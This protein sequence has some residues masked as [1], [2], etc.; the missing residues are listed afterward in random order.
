ML[1]ALQGIA[2]RTQCLLKLQ[3]HTDPAA[4]ESNFRILSYAGNHKALIAAIGEVVLHHP[5]SAA[6]ALPMQGQ[7][8]SPT[9][10][11]AISLSHR[12]LPCCQKHRTSDGCSKYRRSYL[13]RMNWQAMS[14]RC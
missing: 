10:R 3:E 6:A 13:C 5:F 9:W 11:T 4:A 14:A 8:R 1:S 12:Y 2:E 7:H